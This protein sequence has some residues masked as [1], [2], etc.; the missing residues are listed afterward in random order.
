[1]EKQPVR[2]ALVVNSTLVAGAEV[3]VLDIASHLDRTR[4][5]P[6]V[7]VL[8]DY[9]DERPT[10]DA[11]YTDAGVSLTYL[12]PGGKATIREA[13]GLLAKEFL[14]VRPSVVHSHLP[15]AV[16]AAG[17]ASFRAGVPHIIHEHQTHKFH[18]WKIRAAYR[19]LR[20]AAAVTLCYATGVEDEL[21]NTHEVL[22]APPQTL[23][24]RSY[25]MR[26]S[27]D[28]DRIER[29]RAST[30]RAAQRRVLGISENALLITSVAR[31]V[32]WK[33]HREL[34][35][36]FAL[37]APRVPEAHLLIVGDGPLR[38]LLRSR[39]KDLGLT[40]RVTMPGIRSDIYETLA[41]SDIFSLVFAYP[42]GTDN[43]T[44]GIAG[45]EALAMGLP[46]IAGDYTNA[47]AEL[48]NG[49]N[50]VLVHP[51][52]VQALAGALER[53]ASDPALRVRTGQNARS[54]I[55]REMS[56][57]AIIPIYERIY[58]LVARV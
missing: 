17:I 52:D 18:S 8:R 13:S 15:D 34:L 11:R 46:T 3:A 5:E 43:E 16:I 51:R 26:N 50:I 21:F 30:S 20:R 48:V 56:G 36:A 24:R 40:Q 1:M 4:F 45:L 19:L 6:V 7:Y 9:R 41:A 37:L 12:R 14:A 29:V 23:S 33:G 25:T 28:T 35:E 39:A 55:A 44:I 57:N 27:V 49:E 22:K 53:L 32:E 2:I 47:D 54:F 31:F 42:E 58:Q 10:L 38:G